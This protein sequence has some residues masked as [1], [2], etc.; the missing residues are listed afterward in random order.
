M[1]EKL[2]HLDFARGKGKQRRARFAA[3][4]GGHAG[5]QGKDAPGKRGVHVALHREAQQVHN[6]RALFKEDAGSLVRLAGGEDGAQG[7]EGASCLA[8]GGVKV[9]KVD[10]RLKEKSEEEGLTPGVVHLVQEAFG[11]GPVVGVHFQQ[12]EERAV[13]RAHKRV[14]GVGEALY[15]FPNVAGLIHLSLKP[16]VFGEEKV[17]PGEDLRVQG[18]EAGVV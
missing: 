11:Y 5:Q 12:G 4:W 18:E 6:D 1:G 3:W 8:L 15:M 17:V 2:E 7:L 10:A 14:R 9:G 13:Q 16:T